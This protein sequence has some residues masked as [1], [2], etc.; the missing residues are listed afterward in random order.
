KQRISIARA[1]IRK[2]KI[3]MLDDSTSA[4]DLQTEAKLLDAIQTYQCTTL[5]IT[6]KIATARQADHILLFDDGRVLAS[7]RNQDLLKKS[8][9][10]RDIVRSQSGKEYENAGQ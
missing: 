6:Q 10:Y 9:L 5:M 4:L 8:E 7:G 3:L 2:P 1:L